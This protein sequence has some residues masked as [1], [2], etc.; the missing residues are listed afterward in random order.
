MA[1]LVNKRFDDIIL[2][3]TYTAQEPSLRHAILDMCVAV[4]GGSA[5]PA[6]T[7]LAI[8]CM[9]HGAADANQCTPV[10]IVGRLMTRVEQHMLNMGLLWS[11]CRAAGSSCKPFE[12]KYNHML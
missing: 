10:V 2:H 7:S 3:I 9:A 6:R 8:R 12:A 1:S 4:I 11:I 5:N